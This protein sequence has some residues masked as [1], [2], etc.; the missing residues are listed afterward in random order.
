MFSGI[1][2]SRVSRVVCGKKEE[3]QE[4]NVECRESL[5]KNTVQNERRGRVGRLSDSFSS[6]NVKLQKIPIHQHQRS[7]MEIQC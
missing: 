3:K 6:L 5:S 7:A 1:G 2:A 4:E